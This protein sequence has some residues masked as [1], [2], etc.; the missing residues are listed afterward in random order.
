MS[1]ARWYVVNVYAGLER[2]VVQA[3]EEL[4][5]KKGLMHFFEQ[6]LVPSESVVEVRKGQKV[7]VEKQY[8]PGYLLVKMV[9]NDET[10]HLV[11]NIPRVSNF[12]GINGKPSPI[13]EAEVNR[14]LNQVKTSTE[15]PR[16]SY[17]YEVGENIRVIDGPFSTFQGVVEE[18]E[19][20]K[21][22]LKVS[23]M[24]FGRP[25]PVELEFS[26]V[27]RS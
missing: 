12:L 14:I 1:T 22:R 6:M 20:D 13:S 8:F 2:K 17:N 11:R 15:K 24:I 16:Q 4:A 25:T 3:I 9:L 18:V 5:S 23:V 10:W 21:G 7:N 27:E 26:Q 19:Q